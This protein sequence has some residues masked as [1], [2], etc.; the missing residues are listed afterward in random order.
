APTGGS[1]GALPRRG[2]PGSAARGDCG[3]SGEDLV[4]VAS[5]AEEFD[6]LAEG[7]V[8][9]EAAALGLGVAKGEARD[10]VLEEAVDEGRGGV[11]HGAVQVDASGDEAAVVLLAP[12]RADLETGCDARL[13]LDGV[14]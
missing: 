11:E 10:A 14:I 2:V 13:Q 12:F 1:A 5:F 4:L 9:A 8:V 6:C 3:G 7:R